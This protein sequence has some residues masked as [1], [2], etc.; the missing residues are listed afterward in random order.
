MAEANFLKY[1]FWLLYERNTD[2][3]M[4]M[5]PPGDLLH[6]THA[7]G[8]SVLWKPQPESTGCFASLPGGFFTSVWLG[9][10]CGIYTPAGAQKQWWASVLYESLALRTKNCAIS[11]SLCV[12]PDWEAEIEVVPFNN[13]VISMTIN[14]SHQ[15]FF[16][17]IDLE[18]WSFSFPIWSSESHLPPIQRYIRE[19]P[20]NS[21]QRSLPPA[22][23]SS[24]R[25]RSCLEDSRSHYWKLCTVSA[26]TQ[27]R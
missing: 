18:I 15:R 24:R 2:N 6:I 21:F 1:F 14:N 19:A 23:E 27:D 9:V 5:L 11:E 20:S 26:Q 22:G 25:W 3:S 16:V 12:F 4:A 17:Q 10:R 7:S 13:S 8:E